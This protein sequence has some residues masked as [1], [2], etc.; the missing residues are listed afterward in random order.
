MEKTKAA[1]LEEIAS[2]QESNRTLQ[3]KVEE[4]RHLASAIDAKD[5]EIGNLS[6]QM[7]V[8]WQKQLE[9]KEGIIKQLVGFIQVYQQNYRSFLKNVQGGLEN[10]VELEALLS[11]KLNKK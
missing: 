2:L 6:Q 5:K 8:K 4:T 10:A 11:E 3:A 1:L 7:S 9:E